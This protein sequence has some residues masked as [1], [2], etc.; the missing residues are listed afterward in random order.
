MWLL[1]L[2][3]N[4]KVR[5]RTQTGTML[6]LL[7]SHLSTTPSH[8]MPS[9][10]VMTT[11]SLARFNVLSPLR[12]MVQLFLTIP[13]SYPAL[14]FNL[15][16]QAIS[17]FP[18]SIEAANQV[19]TLLAA[20]ESRQLPLYSRT[21]NVLLSD[22]FVTLQLVKSLR[23]RMIHDGF[24][25]SASQLEAYLR[26]FAK[27][28]AIHDANEYL[29]AIRTLSIQTGNPKVPYDPN[30][31]H[32]LP[33]S[34]TD[35]N[36]SPHPANTLSL[37]A[38]HDDSASAFQYLKRLLDLEKT[39]NDIL[40]TKGHR[41]S[42]S[43][44]PRFSLPSKKSIDIYDWTTVL[45]VASRDKKVSSATLKQLL[46]SARS[47]TTAF[48]PTV[49][50]YTVLMRGLL[51]RGDCAG[52]ED[53]WESLIRDGLVLDRKALTVGLQVLTR[54]GDP[55]K[56]FGVLEFFAAKPD[57]RGVVP[58]QL[59][60]RPPGRKQGPIFIN[61]IVMNEFMVSLLRI[62][63]PDVV[64]KLWDHMETLYGVSPDAAS[65]NILLKSARLSAKLDDSFA[66]VLSQLASKNPFRKHALEP[67]GRDEIVGGIM[68][69]L[70]DSM[71][72]KRTSYRT[73]MWNNAPAW[74]W[75][76]HVFQR[77]VLRNWPHLQNI[78]PP[79]SAIH[80]LGKASALHPMGELARR[81]GRL[82]VNDRHDAKPS[83]QSHR[84][85]QVDTFPPYPQIFPEDATFFVY[86]Q[87]LGIQ[88][89]ASEIP[90]ALAW[91]RDLEIVPSTDTLAIALVFWA[92]VSLHAPLI[93]SLVGESSEYTKLVRWIR[94][95][96]GDEKVPKAE[97]IRH[98]LRVVSTIR[99]ARG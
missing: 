73:V 69:M 52:A 57:A 3:I 83:N 99:D 77:V 34:R 15:F 18:S 60:S 46:E 4:Q 53:V 48:R 63:R 79:A 24:V 67:S 42:R 45:A 40:D 17:R 72:K 90:L 12:E 7:Y 44:S 10:L 98:W 54:V 51:Y 81:F 8:L 68:Q 33:G 58:L 38:F 28:G 76:I 75:A 78:R 62:G 55:H 74:Q 66:G 36:S 65:L 14:Q 96:V 5:K 82:H 41:H 95:W 70:C 37:A 13:L 87:L 9:L 85:E 39:N 50:T 23:A 32:A 6:D 1:I 56:A 26:V 64:F 25:P 35:H 21:Y 49:A 61:T 11:L 22:R 71:G 16:L 59:Q 80:S 43:R 29:H 31:D 47:R 92:E 86:I 30:V 88:S 89:L 2:L 19:V 97:D 84:S 20:M 91:M 94:D 27:N 93:E